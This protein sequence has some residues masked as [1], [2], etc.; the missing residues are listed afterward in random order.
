MDRNVY[1][2][3]GSAIVQKGLADILHKNFKCSIKCYSGFNSLFQS[4]A[5]CSAKSIIFIEDVLANS[6]EYLQFLD[7]S[8]GLKSF[9]I[10]NCNAVKTPVNSQYA[11]LLNDSADEIYEK[12]KH[13]FKTQELNEDESEGL[14][15]REI[16]VLKL[17]AYGY[18]NKEIAEKLFISTHTVMSHRKNITEKLGI[19][20]ISGL[21]VYAIINNYIDTTNLDIKDLI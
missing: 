3:H 9:S 5:K 6:E 8:N 18:S 10:L 16:D 1:I 17:V 13:V 2:V 7:K 20:S 15:N 19:K 12:V 21:T 11:I 14:S 4:E